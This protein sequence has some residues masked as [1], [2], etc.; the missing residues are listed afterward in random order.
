VTVCSDN[1]PGIELYRLRDTRERNR[2]AVERTLD[3]LRRKGV[4]M[5]ETTI[6]ALYD[7]ALWEANAAVR[8]KC[9]DL[10]R[11][12]GNEPCSS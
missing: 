3:R 1:Q 7:A 5:P 11:Q 12:Y 8:Q 4:N 2:R 6:T 9:R 10:Y